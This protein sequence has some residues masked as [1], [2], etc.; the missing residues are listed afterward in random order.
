MRYRNSIAQR[1]CSGS[2]EPG[3]LVAS[4]LFH[5]LTASLDS[6][7]NADRGIRTPTSGAHPSTHPAATQPLHQPQEHPLPRIP[8]QQTIDQPTSTANQLARHLDHRRTERRELHSQHRSSLRLVPRRVPGRHRH[9]QSTPRLQAPRQARHHHI[10][11]GAPPHRSVDPHPRRGRSGRE[12]LRVNGLPDGESREGQQHASK[13]GDARRRVRQ[14][15]RETR[16]IR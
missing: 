8:R 1:R 9:H 13:A 5:P 2:A 6:M 15:P 11:P 12:Y 3:P 10:R 16:A 14:S 4:R 7:A